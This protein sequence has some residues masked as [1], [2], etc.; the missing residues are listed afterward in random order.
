MLNLKFKHVVV[1]VVVIVVA[2]VAV[3]DNFPLLITNDSAE[4]T[5]NELETVAIVVAEFF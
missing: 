4:L 5:M 1:D 3:V 2:L